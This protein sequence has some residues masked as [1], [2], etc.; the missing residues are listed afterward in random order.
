[1]ATRGRSWAVI[2]G[3]SNGSCR[4]RLRLAVAGLAVVIAW[5]FA[6]WLIAEAI[7][8]E[9]SARLVEHEQDLV[10]STA[11]SV[12]ANVSFALAHLRS[13]PQVI[14]RQPDIENILS[15]FG[16]D[17]K[18]S[19]LPPAEFRKQLLDDP[20]LSGLAG[21]LESILAGLDVDQIWVVNAAGDCI[22]SGGFPA[23]ST[24][25]GVNYADREYFTMARRSGAGRQ[26][27]VGRTTNTPG[28]FYSAPVYVANRFLGI[29][30]V[31]IDVARLSRLVTERNAFITDENGVV[32]IS[33][34][35]RF[36]MMTVPGAR[37]DR[38]KESE[39]DGRYKQ[40][41]FD[42]IE[43]QPLTVN[44]TPLVTLAG[45][46]S[47]V[48]LG[49]SD[50]QGDL[51]KIWVFKEM[52][53][54]ARI[55]DEG[56]WILVLL[57]V[58]GATVIVSLMAAWVHFQRAR[59]HQAEIGRINAELLKLNEELS[60]QA[61][62]DAL[63]GCANRRHF[64]GEL[65]NELK[66]ATR[67]DLPCALAI[68]DIDHFKAVNDRYGHGAGDVLLE[69]FSRTVARCLRSSDLFGRIGGEE[70]ALLLP[71][72]DLAGAQ[73]LAERIRGTVEQSSATCSAVTIHCT[74]SIGIVQWAGQAESVENLLAR[75]D[76]AMYEAKRGGRNRVC[77]VPATPE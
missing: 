34:E 8:R 28:I 48:V 43:M 58:G 53:E 22:A 29:V 66:R 75:A 37:T 25:T 47:P 46:A 55:R 2:N 20:D 52:P 62:F 41:R 5:G 32:I 70:F 67:F 17:A 3:G 10:A 4:K 65:D 45:R 13:I 61:R 60:V 31:K 27:A 12:G 68:L 1:M 59:W 23:E 15:R 16:P 26:F 76:Q 21:R 50:S 44:G 49:T 77:A 35:G 42:A 40:H 69:H 9:R 33:W 74:V 24:A 54:L 30:T 57:F 64:L 38:M 51:L 19:G 7:V 18:P 14:A 71:Q 36:N 39:L 72:T 11:V 73:E 6:A 56:T 63:T